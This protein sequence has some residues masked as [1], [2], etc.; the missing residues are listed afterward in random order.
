MKKQLMPKTFTVPNFGSTGKIVWAY[1]T[2]NLIM[3]LYTAIN[4]PYTALMG[5]ISADSWRWIVV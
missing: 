5:V 2:F 3:M 1:V 4:I